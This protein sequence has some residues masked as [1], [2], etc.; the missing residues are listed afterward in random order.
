MSTF[1]SAEKILKTATDLLMG[2][3]WRMSGSEATLA[4]ELLPELRKLRE[5]DLLTTLSERVARSH[6][7]NPLVRRFQTQGLIETGHPTAA[8]EVAKAALKG[9]ADSD[10]EWS[11][12]Y[13]LIGRAYKQIVMDAADPRDTDS[14]ASL[15]KSLKAYSKPYSKD[16]N[17]TWHAINLAAVSSFAT[18]TGIELPTSLC[19]KAL[20]SKIIETIDAKPEADRDNWDAA[21]LAE[22]YMAIGDF[23]Q[24]ES[25]LKIYLSDPGVSAFDV[26]S[27]LRQFSQVWGLQTAQDARERGILQA[28]RARLLQLPGAEINLRPQEVKR[29]QAQSTP[30]AEQLEAIL[31][32][33]GTTSYRWW[34]MGLDAAC[35]VGAVYAGVDQRIGTCFL[36][37]ASDIKLNSTNELLV[38][39]N[40]HVINPEGSG[41]AL[42]PED[43]QLAFEAIDMDKRYEIKEVVW[44][45]PVDQHDSCLLRLTEEPAIQPLPIAPS[46]P[47]I[48]AGARVY[49]IGYPTGG[50]L[51]FSMQDN[52]L[53]D[54]EGPQAGTPPIPNVLRIHYRAPTEKGSSGSPVFNRSSWQVIALHHAGGELPQL[55]GKP[56]THPANE[57][58]ALTSI[59]AAIHASQAQT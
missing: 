5:F 20:A 17:N 49:V 27:T 35:A 36:V 38:L 51:A 29:L 42:R 41:G 26:G 25:N 18:R 24:V 44:C 34:K 8:I 3:H 11:E 16:P 58:I 13:G 28:L 9:L 37:K 7:R 10:P 45:S 46:L 1:T 59:I 19:A 6:P 33:D 47:L 40:F 54:H 4:R 2:P 32:T 53:L 39:T 57:G 12:L 43:A 55:N 23:T 56:G 21:T 14:R 15:R 52:A 30:S 31:G 48:A 50:G 22:A